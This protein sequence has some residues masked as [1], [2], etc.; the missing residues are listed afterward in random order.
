MIHG[1]VAQSDHIQTG[2][3]AFSFLC[4]LNFVTLHGSPPF[5]YRFTSIILKNNDHH[6]LGHPP[7]FYTLASNC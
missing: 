6:N 7:V 3:K 2:V 5:F 4:C 1:V